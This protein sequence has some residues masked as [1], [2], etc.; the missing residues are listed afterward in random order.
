MLKTDNSHGISFCYNRLSPMV[1]Y[2]SV[3]RSIFRLDWIEGAFLW[4]WSLREPLYLCH[5]LEPLKHV[6]EILN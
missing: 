4:L 1:L 3:K 5:P 2:Y 6:K